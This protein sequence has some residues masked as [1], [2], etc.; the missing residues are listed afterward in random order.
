M[1]VCMYPLDS[2]LRYPLFEQ[3]DPDKSLSSGQRGLFCQ[4]LSA[5]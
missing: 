1:Y 5:G 4:H 2:D 3:P